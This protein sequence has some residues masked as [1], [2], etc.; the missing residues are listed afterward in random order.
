MAVRGAAR[1][2]LLAAVLLT[3]A[4]GVQRQA[5]A[6]HRRLRAIELGSHYA[7]NGADEASAVQVCGARL[8]CKRCA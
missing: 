4:L 3:S 8:T 7:N 5:R 6:R 2:L 1:R